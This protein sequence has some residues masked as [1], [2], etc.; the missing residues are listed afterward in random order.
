MPESIDKYFEDRLHFI[1]EVEKLRVIFVNLC[2]SV[3]PR[4]FR[5]R[6]EMPLHWSIQKQVGLRLFLILNWF[7]SQS[8]DEGFSLSG[9]MLSA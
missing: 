6:V 7:I 8:L 3:D 5:H 4:F 2:D 1:I 9:E